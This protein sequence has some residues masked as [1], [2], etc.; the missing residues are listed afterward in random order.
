VQNELEGQGWHK[1]DKLTMI[2]LLF[3]TGLNA[4]GFCSLEKPEQLWSICSKSRKSVGKKISASPWR[5]K[6]QGLL[7]H[8]QHQVVSRAV[9]VNLLKRRNWLGKTHMHTKECKYKQ[10]VGL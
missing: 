2:V 8:L 1:Q 9:T 4:P 3:F 6:Q 5:V 10:V 7:G